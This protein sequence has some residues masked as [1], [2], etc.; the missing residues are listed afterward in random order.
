MRMNRQQIFSDILRSIHQTEHSAEII[1]YGS[2]ARGD[3]TDESDWDLLILV[4]GLTDYRRTDRIRHSLY[5]VELKHGII[6]SSIIR[7]RDQWF[8]ENHRISP[9]IQNIQKDGIGI[10]E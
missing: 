4:D 5:N 3:S 7:S 6:L 8:T 1:L 9:L 2:Q 10:H